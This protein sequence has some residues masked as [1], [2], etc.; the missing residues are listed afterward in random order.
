VRISTTTLRI[1]L[2]TWVLGASAHAWAE[3]AASTD[4][5][6]FVLEDGHLYHLNPTRGLLAVA[7]LG[8]DPANAWKQVE[9][10]GLAR[11]DDPHGWDLR[12]GYLT[13]FHVLHLREDQLAD[14]IARIPLKRIVGNNVDYPARPTGTTGLVWTSPATSF[15][16]DRPPLVGLDTSVRVDVVET[17]DKTYLFATHPASGRSRV[18]A[19]DHSLEKPR[20]IPSAPYPSVPS[21]DLVTLISDS[22]QCVITTIDGAAMPFRMDGSRFQFAVALAEGPQAALNQQ[23]PERIV[24]VERDR[25]VGDTAHWFARESTGEL[26][27]QRSLNSGN[28]PP[29]PQA[30]IQ[31]IKRL[32]ERSDPIT[33]SAESDPGG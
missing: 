25:Q 13:L 4:L 14:N 15:R 21:G 8:D 9:V 18:Y 32:L 22:N 16:M 29:T 19:R 7:S 5:Q 28:A 27:Y 1:V 31:Q 6:K 33:A 10:G 17:G 11:A 12:G 20:W 26:A 24:V 30:R 23:V 3:Q 2:C